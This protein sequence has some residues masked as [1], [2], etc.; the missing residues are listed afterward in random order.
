MPT[1][2][3]IPASSLLAVASICAVLLINGATLQA[4]AQPNRDQAQGNSAPQ[5]VRE[6]NPLPLRKF[7]ARVRMMY[8]ECPDGERAAQTARTEGAS[9]VDGSIAGRGAGAETVYR[10]V[11]L[12]SSGKQLRFDFRMPRSTFGALLSKYLSSH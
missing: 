3:N 5:N 11:K 8:L 6:V 4:N 12:S 9:F 7:L 1:A 10:A 2:R